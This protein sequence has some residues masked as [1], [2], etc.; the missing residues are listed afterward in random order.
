MTALLRERIESSD[1]RFCPADVF[2]SNETAGKIQTGIDSFRRGEGK[3]ADEVF[4]E[5]RKQYGL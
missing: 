1:A 2:C 3:P 4:A 5:L